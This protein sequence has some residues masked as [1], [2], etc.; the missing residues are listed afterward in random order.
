MPKKNEKAVHEAASEVKHR[1][2]YQKIGEHVHSRDE[3]SE[4]DAR[5]ILSH[6]IRLPE[7]YK[8]DFVQVHLED[9]LA[10]CKESAR[11]RLV[12]EHYRHYVSIP[13]LAGLLSVLRRSKLRFGPPVLHLL[14]HIT[15][16]HLVA[17]PQARD[18]ELLENLHYDL[19]HLRETCRVE[20]AELLVDLSEPAS[21]RRLAGFYYERILA[22]FLSQDESSL[23]T[24]ESFVEGLKTEILKSEAVQRFAGRSLAELGG[25]PKQYLRDLG[26]VLGSTIHRTYLAS[27]QGIFNGNRESVVNRFDE[28]VEDRVRD[29]ADPSRVDLSLISADVLVA[30]LELMFNEGM[31]GFREKLSRDVAEAFTRGVPEA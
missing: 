14:D 23:V 17:G 2:I 25:D 3:L 18:R 13:C 30:A 7:T 29:A 1:D 31:A 12:Q 10:K 4:L 28:V 20:T 27:L 21:R 16:L 15:N 8:I 6:L 24:E 5:T 9:F 11:D 22:S 19:F 26:A